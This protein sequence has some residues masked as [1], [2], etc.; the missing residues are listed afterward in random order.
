MR[1]LL[2]LLKIDN[3]LITDDN[4]SVIKNTIIDYKEVNK[5]LKTQIELSENFLKNALTR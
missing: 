4:E 3:R 2:N 1:D 5:Q